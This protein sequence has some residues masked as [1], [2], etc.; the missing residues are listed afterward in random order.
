MIY[1]MREYHLKLEHNT[2]FMAGF[3]TDVVPALKRCGLDLVGA[4]MTAIGQGAHSDF[5]WILR[6]KDLADRGPAF[7]KLYVDPPFAAFTE[8]SKP[9]MNGITSK[10]LNPTAFNPLG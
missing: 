6:W 2:E 5:I 8:R 1:E 10:L 3:E 7:A 9:H 4:W